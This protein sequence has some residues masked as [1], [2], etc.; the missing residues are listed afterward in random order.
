MRLLTDTLEKAVALIFPNRCLVCEK[1]TPLKYFCN[2]CLPAPE[3]IGLKTCKKCGLLI[4][5]C[6]CKFNFY[7]FDSIISCLEADEKC[8]EAFYA[9]KFY[10]NVTG[11]RF[12][13]EKM[14]QRIKEDYQDLKIDIVTFVPSHKSSVNER[15]FDQVKILAKGLA[16]LIKVKYRPL[17]C[18]PKKS[19]KQHK[20]VTVDERFRNVEGKYR[21]C[22]KSS[23]KGK[24]ILLVD[25][26]KTTGAT[27]S[28][29]AKELKLS[30][31]EKVIVITALTVY[32][33][34]K[35]KE[36]QTVEKK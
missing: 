25:D 5:D 15:G 7:Y 35:D 4:K 24:T 11:S 30:G 8:K 13:Y 6:S 14:A 16:K 29:C 36:K 18:Q 23:I 27:L 28:Q 12:F 26:I 2:D 3:L 20:T 19:Q 31:A 33:K 21:F 1:I 9:Y 17:L 34:N 10:G 32:P 22:G